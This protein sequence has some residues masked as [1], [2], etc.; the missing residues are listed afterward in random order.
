MF[1]PAIKHTAKKLAV[2]LF[3]NGH[4]SQPSYKLI[5]L[6]TMCIYF[7]SPLIAHTS[8]NLLMLQSLAQWKQHGETFCNSTKESCA[9]SIMKEDFPILLWDSSFKKPQHLISGFYRY[10][11]CP[12][13]SHKK[14]K[15]LI[16]GKPNHDYMVKY[17]YECVRKAATEGG[18]SRFYDQREIKSW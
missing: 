2:I 11:L 16:S 15:L 1:L 13:L 7:A 9:G 10:G 5:E 12:E 14:P 3:F 17:V 8:C 18:Y 6:H 4:H